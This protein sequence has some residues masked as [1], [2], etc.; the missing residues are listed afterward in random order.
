MPY[1][2]LH[3]LL[4]GDQDLTAKYQAATAVWATI[5]AE[6]QARVSAGNVLD[7]NDMYEVANDLAVREP[8]FAE[9]AEYPP[10]GSEIMAVSGIARFFNATGGGFEDREWMARFVRDALLA[11]GCSL[12][13]KQ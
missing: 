13:T 4:H 11:S 10:L 3:G 9:I 7:A 5:L 12:R 2:T 8:E 1:I 6:K